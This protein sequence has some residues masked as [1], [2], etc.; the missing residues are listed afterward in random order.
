MA[1]FMTEADRAKFD[2]LCKKLDEKK[3]TVDDLKGLVY[4]LIVA[5]AGE[6]WWTNELKVTAK[7]LGIYDLI[8]EALEK[9][10]KK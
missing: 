2:R 6:G 1:E 9:D 5:L 3:L 4:F 8:Q 10:K 7:R